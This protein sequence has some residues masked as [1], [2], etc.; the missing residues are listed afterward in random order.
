MTL[1]DAPRYD[2]AREHRRRAILFGSA[3]A[4]TLVVILFWVFSGYPLDWP[5]NWWA[6]LRGRSTINAFF[7]DVEK[8]DLSD[9]YAVWIDDPH[10]QQHQAQ[11]ASYPY[12]R[13]QRDWS[14]TSADN[15][16]GT[17]KAHQIAAARMNGNVL[18]VGVFVNNSKGKPL[19]LAYDPKT[20][21]LGFSPV[22]LYLGP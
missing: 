1:L 4:F 19:F 22:E 15:D 3:G 10:W 7:K 11:L 20:K 5:W 8:N 17:V 6:H 9:A 12:S 13:F 21:Q 16:Y 2:E 18:V 14:P